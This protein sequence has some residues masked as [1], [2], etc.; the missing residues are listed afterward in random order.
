ML[1]MA[2]K[3]A[4]R[5]TKT[6]TKKRSIPA[7]KA[8]VTETPITASDT[9]GSA[10][11]IGISRKWVITAGV[12]IVVIA[13]LYVMRSW[14][15]VAFV[16]GQP[17]TRY[18]LIQE[19]ERQGGKQTL[20]TLVTKALIQ[21]EANKQHVTV[22]DKEVDNEINKIK[23]SVE[24]QGQKLDQ[25]LS[26][27]GMTMDALKEQVRTQKL[28][29]KMLG[30]NIIVTDKEVNDYIEQNKSTFPEG[31][32]PNMMKSQV[33]DQLRQQKLSTKIQS[34]LQD[35]QAKAKINYLVNY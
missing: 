2:T 13:L 6:T 28:V 8:T 17:I 24:K 15:V 29:E 11:S 32:D 22:S 33:K 4:T 12:I 9:P 30:K 18:A 35:L 31:T 10:M 19:L 14:F 21:Q 27:Q 25:L 1:F 20:N 5:T 3:K 26:A 7:R 23:A 34:W 16:N